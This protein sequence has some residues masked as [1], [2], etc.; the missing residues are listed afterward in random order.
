MH[1][2]QYPT[3]NLSAS[4][5]SARRSVQKDPATGRSYYVNAATG[6]SQWEPPAALAAVAEAAAPVK[7]E[8]LG[9]VPLAPLCRL[10]CLAEGLFWLH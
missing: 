8:P 3:R 5:L 2:S 7:T 10:P 9:E 6:A 1:H 4:G